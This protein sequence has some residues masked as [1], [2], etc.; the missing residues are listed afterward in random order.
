[1]DL[2]RRTMEEHPSLKDALSP[3][4][5]EEERA[6]ALNVL[7]MEWI[8]TYAWAIPSPEALRLVTRLADSQSLGVV[9]MGAGKG[10]WASL[11]SAQGVEV[12]AYDLHVP[13]ETWHPVEKVGSLE[14]V[15]EVVSSAGQNAVLM[16]CY[17]DDGEDPDVNAEAPMSYVALEV[18][19][20]E[21]V[22]HVGELLGVGQGYARPGCW[23]RTTSG[24]SQ[25]F[26]AEHFHCVAS[27]ELPSWPTSNDCISVWKRTHVVAIPVGDDDDD[28]DDE[29]DDDGDEEEEE[30]T[31]FAWVPEEERL[32]ERRAAPAY[33]FLLS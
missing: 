9:E 33:Q 22:V 26:L 30:E 29:D 4:K 21:Y 17:P 11:L 24:M 28:G 27:L 5:T 14:D 7:S 16:L 1:M 20:G 3:D 19:D 8:E 13:E 10:Y 25:A 2:Y 18:F 6:D 12:A 32:P 15:A 23:G 31:L